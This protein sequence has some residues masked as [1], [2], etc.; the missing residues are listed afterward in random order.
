MSMTEIAETL[1]VSKQVIN[2]TLNSP[3]G[4]SKLELLQIQRDLDATSMSSRIK[5]G[6]DVSL[7][8]LNRIVN[9]E[10]EGTS[11]ALRS[12]VACTLLDRAGYG[13]ITKSVN[14]AFDGKL[15]EQDIESLTNRAL[16][17]VNGESPI[18]TKAEAV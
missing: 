5:Q 6:A 1:G 14:V 13:A 9:G 4:K 17:N 15:T 11:I 2:Y 7:N 10:E 12:K 18:E 8:L 16:K 3:M